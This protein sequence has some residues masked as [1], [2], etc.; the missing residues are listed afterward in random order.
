MTMMSEDY[1]LSPF[2][3]ETDITTMPL[4]VLCFRYHI[5]VVESST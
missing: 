3:I 4:L 1:F 5:E 2:I